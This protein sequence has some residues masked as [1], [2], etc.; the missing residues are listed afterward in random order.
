[1]VILVVSHAADAHLPFITQHLAEGSAWC[2]LDTD[3]YPS[4]ITITDGPAGGVLRLPD[5]RQV[6][7][8]DVT[9]V[10]WRRPRP[11]VITGRAPSVAA[12][13]ERQSFAAL[14]SLLL[15]I[16][17]T[18]INHPWANRAAED[19]PANL[20]R[21]VAYHLA[22]PDWTVTND[23]DQAQTFAASAGHI[24]VKPVRDARVDEQQLFW[25]RRIEDPELLTAVGPEPYLLQRFIDKVED[26]RV[27]VVAGEVFAVAIDSQSDVR[28]L[29]DMR[30]GDLAE[31]PHQRVELPDDVH[32]GVIGLTAALDLRFAALDFAVDRDGQ[33]W[34]LELNPNGQWA[35]LEEKV[36]VP[37]GA[38]IAKALM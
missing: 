29:V 1:M 35:W 31:L 23:P 16:D 37:I 5:D 17:A 27:V 3:L 11:P 19:K 14:D 4:S 20:R 6:R 21:A 7:I 25:T 33:F 30:A 34:F 24:I 8:R 38:T 2:V 26:V 28:S 13:A 12:W 22:V 36:G 9:G 15:G 10:V 32:A 18:W